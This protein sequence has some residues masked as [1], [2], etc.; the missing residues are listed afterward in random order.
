MRWQYLTGVADVQ[1]LAEALDGGF[2]FAHPEA[3]LRLRD[4]DR[5]VPAST[6]MSRGV[7]RAFYRLAVA[8]EVPAAVAFEEGWI[9]GLAGSEEEAKA[10]LLDPSL[11]LSAR[12]AAARLLRAPS[13]Q[14]ALARERAEFALL[15]AGADKAE[16]IAAFRSRGDP[17]FE[18]RWISS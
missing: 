2:V 12:L 9:D 15:Q 4:G 17:R 11:S 18:N 1:A 3:V 7:P 6:L 5:A 8:P 14:A 10:A 16:G 13:R